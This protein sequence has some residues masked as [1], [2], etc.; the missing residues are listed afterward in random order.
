MNTRYCPACGQETFPGRFCSSCGEPLPSGFTD[1]GSPPNTTSSPEPIA[2]DPE[3]RVEPRKTGSSTK[4]L[5]GGIA[6]AVLILAAIAVLATRAGSH[7]TLHGSMTL[8]GGG[9]YT[10][11][12]PCLGTS[13][14]IVDFSDMRATAPIKILDASGTIIGTGTL[15]D[16]Q[17][18]KSSA[19][20]GTCKFTFDIP[21]DG[22]SSH[23]EIVIADR[24]PFD[25]S[26]PSSLDLSLGGPRQ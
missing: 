10:T 6:A 20:E 19:F 8:M 25:F 4:F 15:G 2:A 7:P 18:I 5:I 1:A 3:G 9:G 13:N 26:D 14:G 22:A 24:P 12:S 17:Y 11:S 16:G 21:L 23:Y